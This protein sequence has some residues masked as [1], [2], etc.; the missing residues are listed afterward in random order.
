MDKLPTA[1]Q[2]VVHFRAVAYALAII[3][4]A[5]A[6]GIS[7]PAPLALAHHMHFALVH[8]A[9]CV[10]PLSAAFGTRL[11]VCRAAPTYTPLRS[12]PCGL[13]MSALITPS[14]NWHT[15]SRSCRRPGHQCHQ[16]EYL[17]R[18]KLDRPSSP[19]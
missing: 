19:V 10:L 14:S 11:A 16:P 5:A 18:A 1:G 7:V 12:T 15:G 17:V 8:T 13:R 4:V 6:C 2:R 3:G 9:V